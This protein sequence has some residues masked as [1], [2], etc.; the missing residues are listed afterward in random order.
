MSSDGLFDFIPLWGVFGGTFLIVLLSIEIGFRFGRYRN[1]STEQEKEA[2]VGT[3][4]GAALGLLAFLLAFIFNIGASRY[5]DRRQIV[6]QE[7]NAIGT[8]YLRAGM[9]PEPQRAELRAL[10]SEYVDVRL[11]GAQGKTA[12]AIRKSEEIQN[13]IWTQ[14]LKLGEKNPNSITVGLF[15]QSVNEVIDLHAE[16]IMAGLRSR[17]PA[18]IWLVLYA[19]SILSLG[20]MGYHGGLM[21]TRRSPAILAVALIFSAVIWLIADLDRPGAGLLKVSQQSMIDLRE[22]IKSAP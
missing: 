12:E 8:A 7:A 1:N 13:K 21:R 20:A 10:F 19:V 3:M 14:V 6:L 15:I 16:R 18:V 2:P 11:A 5:D 4:V 17:I 22:S 9:L